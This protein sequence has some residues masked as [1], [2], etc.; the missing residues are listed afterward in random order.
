MADY[1]LLRPSGYHFR[2]LFRTGGGLQT[3]EGLRIFKPMDN[4]LTAYE[5]NS[6]DKAWPMAVGPTPDSI[7]NHSL[8]EGVVVPET[9]G[10]DGPYRWWWMIFSCSTGQ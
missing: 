5:M 4:R 1:F 7:K 3:I 10:V 9:G 2:T 6:G 8:L